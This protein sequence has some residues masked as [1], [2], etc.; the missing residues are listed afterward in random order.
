[1]SDACNE[2]RHTLLLGCFQHACLEDVGI[3]EVGGGREWMVLIPL[4]FQI[5]VTQGELSVDCFLKNPKVRA[6]NSELNHYLLSQTSKQVFANQPS[7]AVTHTNLA[8]GVSNVCN[9]LWA[10]SVP[11]VF[12]RTYL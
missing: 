11:L 10:G 5:V 3:L 12:F 8:I 4:C 1:M 9:V 2:M 7:L 6:V